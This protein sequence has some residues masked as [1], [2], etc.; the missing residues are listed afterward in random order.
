MKKKLKKENPQMP[1]IKI[2]TELKCGKVIAITADGVVFDHKNNPEP[3]TISFGAMEGMFE[4]DQN[5]V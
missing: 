3:I 4:H 1:E 5:A 2:G